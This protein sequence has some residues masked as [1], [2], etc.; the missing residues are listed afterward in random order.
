MSAPQPPNQP[1]QGGQPN[2]EQQPYGQQP[3]AEQNPALNA[4][5]P[6]SVIGGPGQPGGPP[7]GD[8]VERTQVVRPEQHQQQGQGDATQM[9]P[10]GSMPPQQPPY[11]PPPSA[12][13]P[14]SPPGGFGQPPGG[15]GQQ[16][17]PGYGQQPPPGYAQGPPYGQPIPGYGQGWRP[18]TDPADPLVSSDFGGWWARGVALAKRCWRQLVILQVG[19]A[20]LT[21]LVNVIPTYI[22]ARNAAQVSVAATSDPA[23]LIGGAILTLLTIPFTLVIDSLVVLASVYVVVAAAMG[24]NAEVGDAIRRGM[25][26]LGPL[27]GWTF[28]AGLITVAGFVACILPGFYFLLVFVLLAPV[29]AFERQRVLAR[30]FQLFHADVGAALARTVTIGAIW[31]AVAIV[32]GILDLVIGLVIGQGS[33]AASVVVTLVVS[34]IVM[35][36]AAVLTTTLAIVTYADLRARIEPISTLQLAAEL[37]R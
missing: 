19:G 29:V 37:E 21:M 4:P 3:P 18:D 23:A 33:V 22:Q 31:V 10:P 7:P 26:R 13:Y 28:V 20:V 2:Q 35:I 16:P 17:P 8:G 5:G 9:V 14:Q 27:V 36:P 11:A 34:A 32:A 12:D 24:G 6:T 30:C 15:F 25:R 1:W